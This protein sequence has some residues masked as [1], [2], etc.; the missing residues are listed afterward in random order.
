MTLQDVPG[1]SDP[2]G[3]S[4]VTG[5]HTLLPACVSPSLLRTVV[6]GSVQVEASATA[7]RPESAQISG[8]SW[9]FGV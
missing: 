2:A 6:L 5:T 4:L 3:R 1:P 9:H 8:I 7:S